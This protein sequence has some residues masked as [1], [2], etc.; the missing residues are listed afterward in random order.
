MRVR[1]TIHFLTLVVTLIAISPSAQ[2][3]PVKAT[4]P[5]ANPTR[6]ATEAP[7]STTP[8]GETPKELEEYNLMPTPPP[9]PIPEEATRTYV[10]PYRQQ[11]S[12]RVGFVT[13]T[14]SDDPYTYLLGISYL[15]PRY[16]SPQ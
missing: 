4:V 13:S 14:D 10:Y 2:A 11:L 15:W 7:T 8:P 9:E 6:P 5:T 3:K 16:T 1:F 12:P